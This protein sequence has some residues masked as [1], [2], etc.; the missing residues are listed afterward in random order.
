MDST[1]DS[2]TQDRP[3]WRGAFRMSRACRFARFAQ[4]A[5]AGARQGR[6]GGGRGLCRFR[7]PRSLLR[8][9]NVKVLRMDVDGTERALELERVQTVGNC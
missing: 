8:A 1:V 6:G 3:R 5:L 4:A 7:L 2:N 9:E